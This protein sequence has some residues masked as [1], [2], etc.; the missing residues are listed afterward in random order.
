MGKLSLVRVRPWNTTVLNILQKEENNGCN[1]VDNYSNG[2][3]YYRYNSQIP[4]I[5]NIKDKTMEGIYMYTIH[6]GHMR[7]KLEKGENR[8]TTGWRMDFRCD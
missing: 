8:H 1:S 5:K 6:L 3:K 2:K 4:R 7:R